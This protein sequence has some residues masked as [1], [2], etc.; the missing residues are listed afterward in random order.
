MQYAYNFNS[1]ADISFFIINN[2]HL[3]EQHAKYS[4]LYKGLILSHKEWVRKKLY[5][6]N[7]INLSKYPY[8]YTLMHGL[9]WSKAKIPIH[10]CISIKQ[11]MT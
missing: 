7:N 11:K 10:K 4:W 2:L 6:N 8:Y 9:W 5:N 3:T 1:K